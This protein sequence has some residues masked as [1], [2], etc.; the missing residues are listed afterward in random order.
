MLVNL[1]GHETRNNL[2][3]RTTNK[4]IAHVAAPLVPK[5]VFSAREELLVA[6]GVQGTISLNQIFICFC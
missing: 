3:A 1:I 4:T 2:E 5:E 6:L